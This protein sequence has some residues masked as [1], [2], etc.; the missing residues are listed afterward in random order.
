VK[1][2]LDLPDAFLDEGQSLRSRGRGIAKWLAGPLSRPVLDYR[3]SVEGLIGRADAVVCST[4]E[5]AE[6]LQQLSDSVHGV[7]DLHEEFGVTEPREAVDRRPVHVVWEGMYPTLVACR[8]VLPALHRLAAGPGVV[9][10]LVTDRRSPRFMNRFGIRD[11]AEVVADWGVEVRLHDWSVEEL[12]R[13]AL[14]ADLAI[15]PVETD[16]PYT[17]G[18]PENRMRIFWRLGLPVV[19]SDTPAHRRAIEVAG[20]E[21]DSLCLTSGDWVGALQALAGEPATRHRLAVNGQAA[22]VDAYADSGILRQWDRVL[23]SVLN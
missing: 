9:V 2:V 15:V 18:K 1:V 3:R 10:H 5:Q 13:V 4:R 6:N 7:L 12:R 11:V 20:L 22:A 23:G 8:Q 19:A 17:R 14:L 21:S 16:D